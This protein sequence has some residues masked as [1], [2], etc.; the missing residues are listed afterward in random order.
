MEPVVDDAY[1]PKTERLPEVAFYYPNPYLQNADWAK[2]LVL[3]FD[4]LATLIPNYMPP[5]NN[6]DNEAI[7]EGLKKHGL[8]HVLKP[9]M[10]VDKEAATQLATLMSEVIASGT[11]DKLPKE[12]TH[13]ESISMSRLGFMGDSG[14]AEMIFDE[15]KKKGLAKDSNDG[16]SIPLHPMVRGLV[17]VLLAQILRPQGERMGLNLVPA[18]DRPSFVRSLEELLSLPSEATAGHVV[19]FDLQIVG[20]DVASFGIDEI[21]DYRKENYKD[22]RAYVLAVKQFVRELSGIPEPER[23]L[24]FEERQSQ[25]DEI[26]SQLRKHSRRAWRKP[27]SF[28]MTMAG[29]GITLYTGN[30]AWAVA[31]GLTRLFGA[32][33]GGIGHEKSPALGPYSFLFKADERL[34]YH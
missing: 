24:M 3:F 18:T 10:V 34:G 6:E 15:L 21:L 4:G 31:G 1:A 23:A 28:G 5:S 20:V 22:Y 30:A 25:L 26:A 16:V 7:I 17:L 29:V 14:L 13:F 27:A 9:E 11:L 2:N 33:F 8:F 32:L 12:E 19:S